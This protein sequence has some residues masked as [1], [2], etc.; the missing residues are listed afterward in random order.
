M[1][2]VKK[3]T[4]EAKEMGEN[5][6]LLNVYV[7]KN[8]PGSCADFFG[9]TVVNRSDRVSDKRITPG[10]WLLWRYEGLK[11]L[12]DYMRRKDCINALAIDLRVPEHVVI[13]TVISHLLQSVVKLHA[14]GLVHRDV[15]PSNIILCD[16][17][18]TFRLIDLGAMA[19]LRTGINYN[20]DESIMDPYY[21]P[22]EQYVL[23]TDA[24]D[25][26]KAGR[27]MSLA[28]SAML[29]R[30]HKPDRFD[31]YSIG[32]VLMQLA[33]PHLRTKSALQAFHASFK[34]CRYD[35]MRWRTI[36]SL[37]E[38]QTAV[39][40]ANGG[41][42][43]ELAAALLRPR[44]VQV[45][46]DG[47]V[48]FT[49]EGKP[50]PSAEQALGFRFVEPA[51]SAPLEP[52]PQPQPQQRSGFLGLF[53]NLHTRVT[54]LE[55]DIIRTAEMAEEATTT[56][57]KLRRAV[58]AGE[59]TEEELQRAEGMLAQLSGSLQYLHGE[60][61]VTMRGAR[62][63]FRHGFGDGSESDMEAVAPRAAAAPATAEPTAPAESA[64]G[65]GAQQPQWSLASVML[66][67]IESMGRAVKVSGAVVERVNLEAQA[68]LAQRRAEDL[69]GAQAEFFNML[70]AAGVKA[71]A[72]W[73]EVS[74]HFANDPRFTAVAADD[75]L[76]LF[77]SYIRMLHEMKDL[78]LDPA[79]Q[80]F[81][82]RMAE[83][84][85]SSNVRWESVSKV[86]ASQPF[87]RAVKPAAAETLFVRHVAKLQQEEA[88]YDR[89]CAAE[90]AFQSCLED[91]EPPVSSRCTYGD[92]ARRIPDDPAFRILPDA[93][94]R[95]VFE[96]VRL[97]AA[98]VEEASPAAMADASAAASW[99]AEE[100]GRQEEAAPA[101]AAA[102]AAPVEGSRV[103]H[104]Q[105]KTELDALRQEQARLKAEYERMEAKLREMEDRLQSEYGVS[106]P[107]DLV[108]PQSMNGSTPH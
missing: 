48:Y 72:Q 29:W 8:A 27:V 43:W 96:E 83:R 30:R 98:S 56:V 3:A 97:S 70:E 39:L 69:T 31:M 78:R 6:H 55:D 75:R 62:R 1:K 87:Y 67:G 86:W 44:K 61:N 35:L 36:S 84:V 23:P 33:M 90:L 52:V 17:D 89:I 22:P 25:L 46:S 54:G 60:M 63:A 74:A 40:D 104:A 4:A 51:L 5:E 11:T 12:R 13:P 102:A 65:R 45:L 41:A 32:L 82:R 92:T 108:A 2:R 53:S 34:R 88:Q 49:N 93:Q 68:A 19:D 103:P 91:L 71:S 59:A 107:R 50:R 37:T 95:A 105:E 42:G 14:V 18:A 10:K 101:S 99:P 64:A 77:R 15:K 58:Q 21:C 106:D 28:M 100:H 73:A 85:T 26:A 66:S 16:H 9:Y 79:E 57:H 80:E 20:P 24:P 94:R 47:H 38:Q 7:Q 81:V 76:M